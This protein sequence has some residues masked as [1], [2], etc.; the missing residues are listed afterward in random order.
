MGGKLKEFLKK[1]RLLLATLFASAVAFIGGYQITVSSKS[2]AEFWPAIGSWIGG[3]ATVYAVC[4]A[5]VEYKNRKR[6]D[7][8][9]ERWE[10]L[11]CIKAGYYENW[12]YYSLSQLATKCCFESFRSA[13]KVNRDYA[14]NKWNKSL[15]LTLEYRSQFIKTHNEFADI[16]KRL[17][18]LSPKR[19]EIFKS[20]FSKLYELANEAEMLMNGIDMSR[21]DKNDPSWSSRWKELSD[22]IS[23]KNNYD[24]V[25]NIQF[26]LE[27]DEYSKG[28]RENVFDSLLK[29]LENP[30]L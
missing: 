18:F 2:H 8:A 7:G 30:K 22:S 24:S 29:K 17:R 26:D 1:Q 28:V 25:F 12:F 6:L 20:D 9:S 27:W 4:I 10:I 23:K 11:T 5:I 19:Y 13:E 15:K 16:A 14:H 3:V 21:F